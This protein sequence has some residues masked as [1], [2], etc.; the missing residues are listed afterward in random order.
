MTVTVTVAVAVA[1]AAAVAA[2]TTRTRERARA[3]M[4]ALPAHMRTLARAAGLAITQGKGGKT[5]ETALV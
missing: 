5:A 1:V 4:R 2:A 3:H